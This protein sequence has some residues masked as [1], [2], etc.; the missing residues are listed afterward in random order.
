MLHRLKGIIDGLRVYPKRMKENLGRSYGLY[1][2][3]RVL[4]ALIDK[5]ITREQAYDIV[6][7]N[8]ML[9]WRKGVEFKDI[10]LKDKEVRKYLSKKEINSIFDLKYYFKNIDIIF[11]RVFG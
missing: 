11:K 7:K 6:Q 9:S 1:N 4:L 5:G 2:S 8:A 10:L 3:Q